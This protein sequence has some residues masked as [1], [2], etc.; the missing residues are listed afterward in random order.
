MLEDLC[1]KSVEDDPAMECVQEYF[2][3]IS[4]KLDDLPKNIS[5]AKARAFLASREFLEDEHFEMIGECLRGGIS[6]D[7]FVENLSASSVARI[8]LFLASRY[9]PDLRLGEA[10]KVGYWPFDH[11]SFGSLIEFLKNF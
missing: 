5:K 4:D 2:D 6:D 10:A 7:N 11:P 1:L 3:C 8:H 9:K